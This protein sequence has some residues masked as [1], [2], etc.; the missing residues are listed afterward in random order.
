MTSG[1]RVVDEHDR[2]ERNESRC[3]CGGMREVRAWCISGEGWCEADDENCD[4]KTED[5]CEGSK[6][7]VYCEKCGR[8][9][10]I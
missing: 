6:E 3:G 10:E 8:K 4:S 5:L 1:N 9:E 7:F 2:Q